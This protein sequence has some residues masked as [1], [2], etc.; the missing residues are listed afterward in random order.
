MILLDDE[1]TLQK[2][3]IDYWDHNS[4]FFIEYTVISPTSIQYHE[5]SDSK[6]QSTPTST[7]TSSPTQSVVVSLPSTSLLM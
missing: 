6:S 3:C 4:E 1:L 7:T 5:S 2:I